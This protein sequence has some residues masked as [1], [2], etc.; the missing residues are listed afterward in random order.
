MPKL[1][2]IGAM[3]NI[4]NFLLAV[5]KLVKILEAVK[6]IGESKNN[7]INWIVRASLSPE[8]PGT[9]A[10]VS[11]AE[12]ISRIRQI[13]AMPDT[14]IFKTELEM[15]LALSLSF[16]IHSVKTGISVTDSVPNISKLK[17][18]SGMRKAE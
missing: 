13:T 9:R 5:K 11:G 6:I 7:L 2:I 17:T 14:E 15:R 4:R 3:L 16:K 8:N 1:Y 12:K 18:K 10:F